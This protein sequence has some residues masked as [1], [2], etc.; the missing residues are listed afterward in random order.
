[1]PRQS[2]KE[3][4]TLFKVGTKKKG[5]DKNTWIISKDINGV[6]RWKLFEKSPTNKQLDKLSDDYEFKVIFTGK[7]LAWID[8]NTATPIEKSVPKE[9]QD[10]VINK[11]RKLF[12]NYLR[13]DFMSSKAKLEWNGTNFIMTEYKKIKDIDTVIDFI[14]S[15]RNSFHGMTV[16]A[17]DGYLSGFTSIYIKPGVSKFTPEDGILY[18]LVFE[19]LE[20]KIFNN[21]EEQVFNVV[22]EGYWTRNNIK[23]T[24]YSLFFNNKDKKS[25]TYKLQHKEAELF[26]N[27]IDEQEIPRKKSKKSKNSKKN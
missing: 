20:V 15:I 23:K 4:A 13:Y 25:A 8:N 12:D 27:H 18:E 5:L 24:N 22:E 14:I 1:M 19:P 6:Q 16:A 3:S 7:L 10:T 21:K 9:N 17:A 2:P 26:F 11:A